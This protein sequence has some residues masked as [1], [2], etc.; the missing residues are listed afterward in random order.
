MDWLIDWLMEMKP[1]GTSWTDCERHT[2]TRDCLALIDF[3][4]NSSLI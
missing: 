4:L 3:S 2:L 1:R